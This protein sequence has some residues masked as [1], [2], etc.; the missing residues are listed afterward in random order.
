MRN[1]IQAM[2]SQEQRIS[3]KPSQHLSL[4]VSVV[5]Y[6]MPVKSIEALILQ[7]LEQGAACV[8]VID[9]SPLSYP[10]FANW[11]P[12]EGVK[13][14]R[15]GRNLGYGRAHNI[16]ILQSI[17]VHEHHLIC[18]PDVRLQP[19]TLSHLC[20]LLETR[21]DVGLCMPKVVGPDAKLHYMCKR[22]PTPLDYLSIYFFPKRR[23]E[24][25]RFRLEM[26]DCSYDREMEVE[27]L[28]GCFMFFR[29]SLLARLGGFDER[30][31]LYFE[32]FDLSRRASR[33][34]RNLYYPSLSIVHEHQRGHRRSAW[35]FLVF[36]W[37][38]IR[39]FNKWGWRGGEPQWA[40][41]LRECPSG[42][43]GD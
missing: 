30:F 6:R 22:A 16:A 34:A 41:R 1:P 13:T 40:K 11:I 43:R 28:S 5:I 20:S 14:I 25:R 15:T 35:L 23:A 36:V 24:E 19:D 9:N 7:F 33:V 17:R 2:V 3:G 8:Y 27:C 26:R 12:P 29:A 21:S 42:D 4:G 39:Y 38:A 18:N 10:T 37:S 32:D 31:F